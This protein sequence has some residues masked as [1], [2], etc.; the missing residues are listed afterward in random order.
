M[1]AAICAATLC[2]L[3]AVATSAYAEC[4]WVLWNGGHGSDATMH[5]QRW[6]AFD[7]RTGCVHAIDTQA[8][9]IGLSAGTA[10]NER[11]FRT[12]ETILDEHGRFGTTW[13][14]LPDTVDPRG[15]KGG[16]R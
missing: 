8:T 7:A 11:G 2:C 12:S 14:C 1:R 10:F 6:D 15:P 5:W 4:A 16:G 9:K 3:L 13:Q